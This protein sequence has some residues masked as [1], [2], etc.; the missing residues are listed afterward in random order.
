MV[1][2]EIVVYLHLILFT[3]YEQ[4]HLLNPFANGNKLNENETINTNIL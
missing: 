4:Q 2:V 3:F 1:K